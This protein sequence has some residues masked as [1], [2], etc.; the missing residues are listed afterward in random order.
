MVAYLSDYER[1]P[2]LITGSSIPSESIV[3]QYLGQWIYFRQNNPYTNKS[4]YYD[5]NVQRQYD[6]SNI[7]KGLVPTYQ[8]NLSQYLNKD[9]LL[10]R[11]PTTYNMTSNESFV[12]LY[13]KAVKKAKVIVCACYD[14]LNGKD[15]KE[16][17]ITKYQDENG[18]FKD[19]KAKEDYEK[20]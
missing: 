13:L 8:G 10:W 1:V 6:V 9:N 20:A 17:D 12:D 4:L 14:Y 19:D 18:N 3:P 11:N 7:I 5:D 16:V 15:I 2:M